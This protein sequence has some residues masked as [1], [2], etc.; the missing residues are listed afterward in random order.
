MAEAVRVP[1]LNGW[2]PRPHQ[3]KL[4]AYLEKGGKRAVE[5]AHRRWGKDD[6][7]LHFTAAAAAERVGNY[8]HMLPEYGQARKAIWD[9]INPHTGTKR[10]DEAFPVA[11]RRR[12][13]DHEMMIEFVNG[14]IWQLVGSDSYNSL[15][16][17]P[18]CGVVFS[19]YSL[20]DPMAW[21]YLRPILAEN[22]GWSLFIY[23]SR[24][25]NHGKRLLEFA[26]GEAG[27]FW[28]I[29]PVGATGVFGADVLDQERREL[30]NEWGEEQGEALYQQEYE[31][32]F[33]GAVYGSYYQRQLAQ[34]RADGRIGQVPH[35]ADQEVYTAWDLGID[36]SMS[37]WFFQAIGGQGVRFV[38]YLE[39]TGEGLPWFAKELKA[40]PY[41]YAE[42]LMPHDAGSR[43]VQTGKTTREV[44]E[45]L[46]I[47]PVKVI[48]RAKDLRTVVRDITTACRNRL[49][50]CWFDETKCARGLSALEGYRAEYDEEKR[51]LGDG[52]RHDWTSHGADSFRTFAVGFDGAVKPPR[53]S[54]GALMAGMRMR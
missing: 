10:I 53:Q 33:G 14:S 23:T 24:G 5:V 1:V 6:V 52:P 28:E 43:H 34:A 8:W 32:S 20:A 40:K 11:M 18:P 30:V 36:D 37:V 51:K 42:H 44:A 7:A 9:A 38:D 26:K 13:R 50:E 12:T 21:A 27:W 19:E 45:G 3:R 25:N 41:V 48:P 2:R 22:G 49:S 54:V 15:V 4:W 46:G 29:S 17:S 47:K 39:A 31:C 35:V 16:G